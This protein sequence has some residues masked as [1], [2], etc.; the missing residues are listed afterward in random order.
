MS[1]DIFTLAGGRP[2]PTKPDFAFEIDFQ[3]GVGPASRVFTATH[4]FIK[5][6]E[7]LDVELV[8]SIDLNIETILVLE[9]IQ[10][11]SIKAFFRNVLSAT[12]DDALKKLDWK[13]L[14]GKYLVRAKYAI[15]RWIDDESHQIGRAH[16]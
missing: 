16:V 7:A 3:R 2:V 1:D 4:D 12:E 15:L 13:P 11:G 10:A 14:V 9:D 5:A 8:R 6:C